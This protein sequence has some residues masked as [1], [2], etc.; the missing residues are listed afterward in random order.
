MYFKSTSNR[1]FF[2][3]Y[4]SSRKERQTETNSK[5]TLLYNYISIMKETQSKI[6]L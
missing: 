4:V 3:Y 2:S 1:H 6:K 5:D